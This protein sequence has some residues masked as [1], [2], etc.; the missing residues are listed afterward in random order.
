LLSAPA[1][2]PDWTAKRPNRADRLSLFRLLAAF[3]F[4]ANLAA[5]PASGQPEQSRLASVTHLPD[6]LEAGGGSIRLTAT[7]L[8]DSIIRVRIARGG[9]FPEDS[10]WA[11]SADVRHQSVP[12]RATSDGFTTASIAVYLDPATLG[13]TVTDLQGRTVSADLPDAVRIDGN[14]FRL[15]KTMPIDEHYFGMG[16][17]TG[18]LDRRGYTFTNWN[19]DAYGFTPSTDPIYKSIP[20]FIG[21]GGPGGSYGLFLDNNWRSTFD[22]GHARQ[23]TLEISAV[24]G[25][26]DYYLIAGPTIAQVVRRYTDLTGKAPLAPL[27]ALGYQ[28][29]RWSYMSEVEV[30]TLAA[31]FRRDRFPIDAIWMDIDYQDRDRPFTVN[32]ATFPDVRKLNSDMLADGIRLVAITDLHVACAP[33]QAYAPYDTGVAGDHFIR[34]AD[35]NVYVAPVWPGPSVFPDFTRSDTRAW[36]GGLYKKFIADGFSGFWNDM[37]EPAIFET[38]TKTMPL[39]NLH[40]IQSDDFAPRVATHAEIHNVYGMENT[41][42]TFE[43]MQRLRPTARPFVLT[44]ASY[45]GG[46][47]YAATWTGDNSS[48]WDHL[49]LSVEQLINLGLS[50]FS[51][52]GADVGGFTGGPSPDLLTRWFEIAAFTPLFRDHSAVGTPRAEP[53]VDGAE[54]LAIR[55]RYVEQRYRLMPY[56]YALAEQNSRT[57]DPIMRPVFYDYPDALKSDCDQPLTFTLGR[58]LLISAPP[59]PESPEPFAI[60]LPAGGWYDYWTGLP[61]K[62][63]KLIETPRLDRLPVF[64]R[65]G[66]IL[67]RQPLVQ[68]TRETPRGPLSLDVYPGDECQG[69][70]YFDDGLSV[71]G[72]SLR[73][74]V[75]CT[76][77]SKG[78]ALRFGPR[79]GSYRPWWKQIAVTVHGP[80]AARMTIPDQPNRAEILIAASRDQDA[81]VAAYDRRHLI[82]RSVRPKFSHG[83]ISGRMSFLG[84]AT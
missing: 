38:P 26:I 82:G 31:R 62:G 7:A 69:E 1:P 16:D 67:P 70:L 48:T 65:A 24:D 47:R 61:V 76:A 39:D 74:I 11:V 43:G 30:R 35:G 9:Q 25:P 6:G 54:Q 44:R 20:F 57:G 19:T 14:S 56:I 51:Y 80:Q 55:K 27:W 40:R 73:Q 37:N 28:Q 10:S 3:A 32:S 75:Q 45:A 68:S 29:S 50:G 46:Q 42:A 71:R 79:K 33:N 66:T 12:V 13:L 23:G 34:K 21:T 49:R 60:C 81:P 53:W 52:S 58:D 4:I 15:R 2:R 8:T 64:V 17:K 77:T 59:K 18:V 5:A 36:W 72:A 41:R 22:F 83:G 63:P 78:I 84:A